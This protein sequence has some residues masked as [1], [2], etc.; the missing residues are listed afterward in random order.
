MTSRITRMLVP[1]D[2]SAYSDK[3]FEYAVALAQQTGASMHLLHAVT[4]L[5]TV[6]V[7]GEMNIPMPEL[8]DQM[9]ADARTLLHGYSEK[10]PAGIA[11]TVSVVVGSPAMTI[12]DAAS[13]HNCDLIVMGTHGRTGL[14]H[15]VM[16]SVA[17][18][19]TRLAPCPVLTVRPVQWAEP[20][21]VAATV[22]AAQT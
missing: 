11:A 10:T 18:R 15:L 1:M 4:P 7:G 17:E 9:V 12:A 22:D 6:G 19:V 16:G 20:V 8:T 5:A 2:F 21:S 13:Q 14:A 3:A